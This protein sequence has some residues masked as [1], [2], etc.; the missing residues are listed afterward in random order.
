MNKIHIRKVAM[1]KE[2]NIS[3][4]TNLYKYHICMF[5]LR[6][7]YLKLYFLQH[8]SKYKIKPKY[9]QYKKDKDVHVN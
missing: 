6:T 1:S 5:K 8:C 7:S 4:C 9:V 3:N 2:Y